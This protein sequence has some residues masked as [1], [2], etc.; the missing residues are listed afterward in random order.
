MLI[1]MDIR[2][3]SFLEIY[4]Q[5]RVYS[6]HAKSVKVYNKNVVA[7]SAL[8]LCD[9]ATPSIQEIASTCFAGLATTWM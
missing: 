8:A 9:E 1:N 3:R 6:A 4:L 5:T 7:R 2:A